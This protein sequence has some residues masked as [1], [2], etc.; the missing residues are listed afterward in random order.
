MPVAVLVRVGQRF[1]HGAVEREL[2]RV[3]ER[4]WC[5]ARLVL[6]REAGVSVGVDQSAQLG[7]H[8][9]GL[10]RGVTLACGA[11]HVEDAPQVVERGLRRRSHETERG[12]GIVGLRAQQVL[13]DAGLHVDDCHA[14]GDHVVELAG[15]VQSLLGHAPA[16]L[17]FSSFLGSAGA[18]FRGRDRLAPRPDQVAGR[19]RERR[20]G[21]GR[22][23]RAERFVRCV[24]ADDHEQA[25]E[26]REA[27]VDA[28]APVV[29]DS[30]REDEKHDHWDQR[31]RAL[32]HCDRNDQR[33]DPR[34]E[35]GDRRVAPEKDERRAHDDDGDL[36][37]AEAAALGERS[38]DRDWHAQDSKHHVE[39]P[40]PQ[41]GGG[42]P[43]AYPARSV[44]LH[45]HL[46]RPYGAGS[47]RRWRASRPPRP[48][49]RR[50]PATVRAG[51]RVT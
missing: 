3:G 46:M 27:G 2:C 50:S 37:G 48:P 45:V 49:V 14:V 44:R 24:D 4:A 33:P 51:C 39:R 1:L 12:G 28:A 43:L 11:E 32:R 31:V 30:H 13:G 26:A 36:E 40:G 29:L 22:K 47:R 8:R 38:D 21:H 10:D 25:G 34:R 19:D 15:D 17:L 35:D 18:L 23:Q 5:A 7:Q 6:D 41:P 16:G 42:G 9:R 20:P